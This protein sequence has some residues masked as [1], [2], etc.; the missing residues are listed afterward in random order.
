MTVTEE[1]AGTD[2]MID[3]GSTGCCATPDTWTLRASRGWHVVLL[4]QPLGGAAVKL[5][6]KADAVHRAPA[7]SPRDSVAARR[8]PPRALLLGWQP[9]R[10]SST[11]VPHGL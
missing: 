8:L 1:M 7:H 11:D 6:L 10:S 4:S 5:P 3:A 2:V 9:R